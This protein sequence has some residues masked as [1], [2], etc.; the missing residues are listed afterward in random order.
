ML[1]KL[2]ASDLDGTIIDKNNN[3]SPKNFDAINK[4]HQRNIDFAICTGKAY[5]VSKKICDKFT[6]SYGIF[7][8]GTQIIDLKTGKELLRRTLLKED[9]LFIVT[10]AKR[11]NYHIHLYTDSEIISEKLEYMDLRNYKL[12]ADNSSEGLK[13]KIVPDI[14]NYIE[15]NQVE[16]FSAVVSSTE[17]ALNQFKTL[18]KV[19]TNIDATF[20]NKRG[21][22]R[23]KIINKDYEYLSIAPTH[24][25][26]NE[27]LNFLSKYLKI[28]KENMLAIGDNIN[29][30][31]MVRES[32]IGVA[33]NG[34][35]DDL[36]KAAKYITKTSVSDGAF[37]EA[38]NKFI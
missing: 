11:C 27:A 12:K 21:K 28:P 34:A 1:V 37:A 17:A 6:A 29:D 32:G 31:E 38:I 36:K 16:A 5:S 24:I 30:L 33:V 9:L 35:Y 10:F 7:G 4:I 22:Y 3:I 18:L 14:L 8:N 13:F 26:K 20:I 2:I 19:N 25:N 23:D 15:K